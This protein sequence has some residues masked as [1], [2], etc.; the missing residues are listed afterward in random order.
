MRIVCRPPRADKHSLND[1]VVSKLRRDVALLDV[2]IVAAPVRIPIGPA[3]PT[4]VERQNPPA[5]GLQR[6]GDAF[7]IIGRA[8]QSRQTD[9]RQQSA[10]PRRRGIVERVQAQPVGDSNETAYR[11]LHRRHGATIPQWRRPPV[12]P[13]QLP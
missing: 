5:V 3:A 13:P 11:L 6:S 7:E 12:R 10:A 4:V 8:R 2:K 1:A 9:D